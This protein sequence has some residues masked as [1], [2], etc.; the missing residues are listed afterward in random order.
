VPGHPI[1]LGTSVEGEVDESGR[2]EAGEFDER[3]GEDAAEEDVR[4][5]RKVGRSPVPDELYLIR[6][7]ELIAENEG[8]VPSIRQVARKLSIGQD[9]ARRLLTTLKGEQADIRGL[10]TSS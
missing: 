10:D 2:D 5:R 9:R 6:L 7:R 4:N 3:I 8:V 1:F